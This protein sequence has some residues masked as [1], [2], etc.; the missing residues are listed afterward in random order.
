M[1]GAETMLR[2]ALEIDAELAKTHFFLGTVAQEPRAL[3]RGADASA[4]GGEPVSARPR[5][6]AISSGACCSLSGSSTRRST[7]SSRCCTID[8]EDLQAHYNLMLAYQGLGQTAQAERERGA[9]PPLQG[10]RVRAG[11]HRPVSPAQPRRQQR[12]PVDPRAPRGSDPRVRRPERTDAHTTCPGGDSGR[13]CCRRCRAGVRRRAAGAAR[14]SPTSRRRR[15]SASCTTAARSARSTCPRRWVRAARSST[16][17]ATAGRTSCSSTRMPWPG[18]PAQT[19][20]CMA[21]YRNNQDGTFTD[22]TAAAGLGVAMYG[23]GVAAAD[24]DNDGRVDIYV[25]GLGRNRLFRNLGGAEVRGRHG[26]GAASAI[27]GFRRAPP[28]STTTATAA[29]PRSSRTTS[30]GRSR[31][32]CSARSTARPSRT[33]RRSRTRARASRSI[34]NRG[35][36]TFEDVDARG[37]AQG[38]ASKALGVALLDYDNDGWLDLF[39]AND[40]Q[41]NRLYENKRQRHVRRRRRHGRAS[42][43]TRPASRAP[44]WAST[45]PTTTA[46]DGRAS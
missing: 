26:H 31:R 38:S 12:A 24:Y 42:P 43:S 8:P 22:V 17:T 4:Q 33:A 20:A 18:R 44:A 19:V 1:A 32:I 5:R 15:A 23:M 13:A 29:R 21:L 35:D 28:G 7:S 3:R 34:R 27:R 25:T 14:R 16:P 40:T 6:A 30:T 46:R 10:R 36:G 39:V 2:R 11:D 37:R 45:P 41:P 9:V